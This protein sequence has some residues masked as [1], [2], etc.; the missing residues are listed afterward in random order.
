MKNTIS[1]G[2]RKCQAI[3]GPGKVC[4]THTPTVVAHKCMGLRLTHCRFPRKH[5]GRERWEMQPTILFLKFHFES[6]WITQNSTKQHIS[7]FPL[8]SLLS[9]KSQASYLSSLSSLAAVYL[10]VYSS[11]L[12][13]VF[14]SSSLYATQSWREGMWVVLSRV[15]HT[16]KQH[17]TGT[18][19]IHFELC[20][21]RKIMRLTS[22]CFHSTPG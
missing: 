19:R 12:Q 22:T 4:I 9:L 14:F 1:K 11:L 15:V 18:F 8:S 2:R 6:A 16:L 7:L 13:R 5:K 21:Q 17:Q 3:S 20:R 10:T